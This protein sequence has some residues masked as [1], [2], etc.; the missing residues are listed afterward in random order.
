[1]IPLWGMSICI[2]AVSVPFIVAAGPHAGLFAAVMEESVLPTE[3][4]ALSASYGSAEKVFLSC[5]LSVLY[6]VL[7]LRS[8]SGAHMARLALFL[9]G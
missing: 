7:P 3:A 5:H 6:H 4:R 9:T 8:N 2:I 1:M